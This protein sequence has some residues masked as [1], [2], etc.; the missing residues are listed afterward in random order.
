M[1]DFQSR[2]RGT[3]RER[4]KKVHNILAIVNHKASGL[5]TCRVRAAA[6]QSPASSQQ[7]KDFYLER[8]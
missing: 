3:E 5:V 6:V 1:V 4:E 7:G 2:R 8:H